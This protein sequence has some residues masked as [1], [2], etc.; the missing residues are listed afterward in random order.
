MGAFTRLKLRLKKVESGFLRVESIRTRSL[1]ESFDVFEARCPHPDYL[2]GWLDGLA[3]GKRIGRGVLH[4]ADYV[5]A[6]EDPLGA[7]KSFAARPLSSSSSLGV[8]E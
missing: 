7:E 2:V 8:T 3:P 5:P 4:A 6:S 1:D